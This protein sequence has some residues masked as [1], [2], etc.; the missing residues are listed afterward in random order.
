MPSWAVASP[1]RMV[2]SLALS[3][4]SALGHPR[5]TPVAAL[6][7]ARRQTWVGTLPPARP[8]TLRPV[9]GSRPWGP[10]TRMARRPSERIV[11]TVGPRSPEARF[12]IRRTQ[13]TR[14]HSCQL[15][16]MEAPW[17][18]A[19]PWVPND[20]IRFRWGSVP[21]IWTPHS[22]PHVL[23]DRESLQI[24]NRERKD[25]ILHSLVQDRVHSMIVNVFPLLS[26]YVLYES[27]CVCVCV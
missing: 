27:V 9:I 10:T 21:G 2:G 22:W 13:A 8:P 17:L 11:T 16:T 19:R 1:L 3:A 18:A 5:S 25:C 4:A 26:A 24:G 23:C 12:A 15:L 20:P 6:S 7:P 14:T